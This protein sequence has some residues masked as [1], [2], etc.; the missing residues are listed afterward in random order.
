VVLSPDAALDE[1]RARGYRMT[2]QRRA[3]VAEIM[4]AEGH[5]SPQAVA[6]R[7]R[8]RLPEVNASTVYRTLELLEDLGIVS[9]AHLERGA[10]YHR[11]GEEAH[12]HLVCSNCGRDDELSLS[13][14][15]RLRRLVRKH[16]GFDPDLA[17]FAISGLC[18]ECRAAAAR[19]A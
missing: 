16:N 2:P 6:R 5:I 13:E 18:A 1:L 12:V 7:V 11:V 15:E 14:T 19:T 10:E 4:R 8:Q 17:H 9:H 3:I